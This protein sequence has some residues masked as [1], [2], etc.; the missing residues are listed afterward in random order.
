M[1]LDSRSCGLPSV[2]QGLRFEKNRSKNSV[3]FS[4][5][6]FTPSRLAQGGRSQWA[7][8]T[9]QKKM[10]FD[11]GAELLHYGSPV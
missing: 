10:H 11:S 6:E 2:P 1:H 3:V 8:F 7:I 4:Q 5:Y 9:P